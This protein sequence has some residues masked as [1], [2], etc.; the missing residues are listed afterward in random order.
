MFARIV[1]IL[2]RM[3]EKN[4][5]NACCDAAI[6]FPIVLMA[7][8]LNAELDAVAAFA[9]D[10]RS[11]PLM[12]GRI[13]A[14]LFVPVFTNRPVNL[15]IAAASTLPLDVTAAPVNPNELAKVL[16]DVLATEPLNAIVAD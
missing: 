15:V 12:A 4:P 8:L 16:P 11:E 14:R 6:D 2:T 13:A 5:P 9:V 7:E 10:L 3:R 1:T